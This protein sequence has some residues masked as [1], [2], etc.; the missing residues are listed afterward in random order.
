MLK[1]VE[2]LIKLSNDKDEVVVA[3]P[4]I[5]IY[6]VEEHAKAQFIVQVFEQNL[7]GTFLVSI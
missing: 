7:D 1:V 6:T 5:P 2:K 4:A 3:L